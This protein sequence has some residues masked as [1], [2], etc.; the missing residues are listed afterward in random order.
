MLNV[1]NKETF[2]KDLPLD[3]NKLAPS[4]IVQVFMNTDLTFITNKENETL[5]ERFKVLIKD[6]KYFDALVAFFYTSGF[7]N[8]YKSLEKTEQRGV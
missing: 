7:Y 6:T 1:I 8:L 3:K 4:Y 2:I 5:L